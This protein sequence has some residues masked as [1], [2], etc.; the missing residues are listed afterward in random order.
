[1]G[2]VPPVSGPERYSTDAIGDTCIT[3]GGRQRG[4]DHNIQGQFRWRA[5]Y[6]W[7]SPRN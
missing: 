7:N 5:S 1:M 3:V 6:W 4:R 2:N